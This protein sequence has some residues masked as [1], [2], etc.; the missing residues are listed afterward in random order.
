MKYFV[1]I[2]EEIGGESGMQVFVKSPEFK[3][4]NIG[5]S[6]DEGTPYPASEW[7]VFHGE[8]VLWRK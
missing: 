2:D 7:I 3:A 4:L 6:L 1:I 8:K 5:I